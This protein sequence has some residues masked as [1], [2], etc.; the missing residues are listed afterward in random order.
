METQLSNVYA[1]HYKSLLHISRNLTA[2]SLHQ[3]PTPFHPL[4]LVSLQSKNSSHTH[5]HSTISNNLS[6]STAGSLLRGRG[7]GGGVRAA[8]RTA[9]TDNAGS[10]GV[11][12][13]GTGGHARGGG[14]GGDVGDSD[15]GGCAE[16]R[17]SGC[18]AYGLFV[19]QGL[20]RME[21]FREGDG[22]GWRC[23]GREGNVLA[24]SLALHLLGAH[25]R[26]ELVIASR[27]VVHWHFVS[28]TPQF[29]P[30]R[31]ATKQGIC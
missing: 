14:C 20:K 9:S 29:E 23:Q 2:S 18:E 31:A 30:G 27:P 7:A 12:G 24:I 6:T 25:E 26:R 21:G 13:A 1:M 8:H 22:G 3:Y 4:Y 17:Y 10:S 16:G 28:V 11:G 5:S 19:S 15:A